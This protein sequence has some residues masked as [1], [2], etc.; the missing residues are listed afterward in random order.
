M[1]TPFAPLVRL[2][3][4]TLAFVASAA[5]ATL[6]ESVGS[7]TA[8]GFS[9]SIAVIYESSGA[10]TF[11]VVSNNTQ[12]TN[13][14]FKREFCGGDASTY[15]TA[16]AGQM[17]NTVGASTSTAGLTVTL[18]S[19]S[20]W[21]RTY[22]FSAI[23]L[24]TP[25]NFCFV[26][27][28]GYRS[29]TLTATLATPTP[30]IS[31]IRVVTD[32][33]IPGGRNICVD[34]TPVNPSGVTTFD[35]IENSVVAATGNVSALFASYLCWNRTTA[36]VDNQ[37]YTVQLRYN[38][39]T[40]K[41]SNAL[42]ITV[43]S[44][45]GAVSN[46]TASQNDTSIP[47]NI[48]ISWSAAT[49]ATYYNTNLAPGGV[50]TAV[51]APTTTTL[52]QPSTT[53]VAVQVSVQPCN[54]TTCG[55]W[56]LAS[57]NGIAAPYPPPTCTALGVAAPTVASSYSP[58]RVTLSGVGGTVASASVVVAG[59]SFAATGTGSTRYV[60]VPLTSGALASSYGSMAVT[61]SVTGAAGSANCPNASFV[62]QYPQDAAFAGQVVAGVNNPTSVTLIAGR[63]YPASFSYSNSGQSTWT[64]ATHAIG[65]Q[66]P[67]GNTSFGLSQIAASTNVAPGQSATYS[68][69]LAAPVSVGTYT[70]QWRSTQTNLEWFGSPST[71]VTVTVIAAPTAAANVQASD[72]TFG[73]RVRLTWT[74]GANLVNQHVV[75]A[76]PGT[77]WPASPTALPVGWTIV[78]SALAADAATCDDTTA[79]AGTTYAYRVFGWSGA[80]GS[81]VG[82]WDQGATSSADNGFAAL[83]ITAAPTPF[84]ASST[85]ADRIQL[86]W[87]AV[88]NAASYELQRTLADA[89]RTPDGASVQ[90]TPGT[91]T[92]YAD[93]GMPRG[94]SRCYRVRAVNGAGA[95][96][97]SSEACGS[98]IGL[99]APALSAS[100]GTV[101]DVTRLSWGSASGYTPVQSQIWRLVS[102]SD[103]ANWELLATLDGIV[104]SW[105]DASARGGDVIADIYRLH[106]VD[107][108]GNETAF[109][110]TSTTS[111]STNIARGY[112]NLA[113]TA[114]APATPIIAYSNAPSAPVA[115]SVTDPNV[116]AGQ[117]ESF[118]FEVYSKYAVRGPVPIPQGSCTIVNNNQLQWT[119]PLTLDFAGSTSCMILVT[120]KGGAQLAQSLSFEVQQFVP[121]APT[122]VAATD[123]TQT[124]QVTVTWTAPVG[125][126]AYQVFRDGVAVGNT[127]SLVW[128]DTQPV[129]VTV[130]AYTVRAV[131][132]A[133]GISAASVADTGFANRAPT[134]TSAQI[135]TSDETASAPVTPTVV[136]AN[137][138]D[139]FT[140]AIATQ[141]A[142]G[143]AAVVANALVYTPRT[144]FSGADSF[145]YT[146]TDRAGASVTGTA[147]VNVTCSPPVIS[148]PA[149]NTVLIATEATQIVAYN[150]AT[151]NT[152][153]LAAYTIK[154][155]DGQVVATVPVGSIAA[156]TGRTLSFALDPI[157]A[158]G[159]FTGE[160]RIASEQNNVTRS[161]TLS[162]LPVTAPQFVTRTL[163]PVAGD[164]VDLEV[165]SAPGSNCP[166]TT[167]SSVAQ[168]NP[169]KCLVVWG[170]L[171]GWL[172]RDTTASTN[173]HAFGVAEAGTV[174]P[175][176]NLFK[177]DSRGTR[178]AVGSPSQTLVVAAAEA[179]VFTLDSDRWNVVQ[180]LSP[181]QIT[182]RQ[183][184]GSACR[185]VNTLADATTLTTQGINACVVDWVSVPSGL[186]PRAT[187]APTLLGRATSVEPATVAARVTRIYPRGISRLVADLSQGLTVVAPQVGYEFTP[188]PKASY[189]VA[190]DTLQLSLRGSSKAPAKDICT[191]T[192]DEAAALASYA[193]SGSLLCFVDW[194]N[195]PSGLAATPATSAP[196]VRG[197]PLTAGTNRLSWRAVVRKAVGDSVEIA[198]G[199]LDLNVVLP[200][201]PTFT[202]SG[203]RKL[204][205]GRYLAP[206]AQGSVAKLELTPDVVGQVDFIITDNLGNT[207]TFKR[208]RSG[209][210]RMI[211][212]GTFPL[213]TTRQLTIRAA[214]SDYPAIATEQSLSALTVPYDF[215]TNIYL[216]AAQVVNDTDPLAVDVVMGRFTAAG[217]AYDAATMGDYDVRIARVNEDGSK[218]PITEPKR[219]S[220]LGS[221]GKLTF[222]GISAQDA[223][224]LKLV[225]VADIASPEPLFTRTLESSARTVQVVKGT[226][227]TASLSVTKAAGPAP[228][229]T[230]A[231]L[232][233]SRENQVAL[234]GIEWLLARDGGAFEIVPRESGAQLRL[235][236]AN[237]GSYQVKARLKNRNTGNKA[238]TNPVAITV[239]LVPTVTIA[240]P[241][242]V[243][244]GVPASF[245][246]TATTPCPEGAGQGRC[247]VDPALIEWTIAGSAVAQP[248][249]GTGPA[250]NFTA[251]ARGAVQITA[252]A[253]TASAQP[254]DVNAWATA[255]YTFI[256]AEDPKPTVAISGP[257]RVE[258]GVS[259]TYTAVV[260]APW[261]EQLSNGRV[262]GEWTL[263]D[264]S[265]QTSTT[266]SFT[267]TSGDTAGTLR[268]TAWIEGLKERTAVT[269]SLDYAAWTYQF[270]S[271]NLRLTQATQY[272]PSPFTLEV[273]PDNASV[274]NAMRAAGARFNFEWSA[275][276][277]LANPRAEGA[278]LNAVARTEGSYVVSV[279]VSDNRG[280][281]QTLSR[282][283]TA[284]PARPF[285]AAL[286]TSQSHPAGRVPLDV[287]ARLSVSGGHPDDRITGYTWTVDGAAVA[288][289]NPGVAQVRIADPGEHVIAVTATSR[290]GATVTAQRSVTAVANQAPTCALNA[291][292]NTTTR[293]VLVIAAC[294]DVDG[295]IVRYAW[296][297]NGAALTSNAD[298]ISFSLPANVTTPYTVEVTA[299][300][301][302]GATVTATRTVGN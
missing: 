157:V 104:Q 302:S 79:V 207:T 2:L 5:H 49:G 139:V 299:T 205:D 96:P 128:V 216:T 168:A 295:R 192:A 286:S 75:R 121:N 266:L 214:Y 172:N 173:L 143:S 47:G 275:A 210:A 95:G 165:R 177:F 174:T 43:P 18:V 259:Q 229:G 288:S 201:N 241:T 251:A 301:D 44:S 176:V 50:G 284:Q 202:I 197:T 33:A 208:V 86:A 132:H 272:A 254:N 140:F 203:G 199:A 55:S 215:S 221:A 262:L 160:T 263:P 46:V 13:W 233:L 228:L 124:D 188:Q 183:T 97:W 279:T 130:H 51:A 268:Y 137:L 64:A 7:P 108:A 206:L 178:Y 117:S 100:Q 77:S 85:Y 257:K 80:T 261:R 78:C 238:D 129:G 81:Q 273:T 110:I 276:P 41:L 209:S 269:A 25:Q 14:A 34:Y 247:P 135:T 246:I 39:S 82:G 142:N 152:N 191:P 296:K 23:P 231:A 234:A 264:G 144:G 281:T 253:R 147:T 52:R 57:T 12:S 154:A 150:A 115:L 65:T 240:G 11:D 89:T 21:S 16:A 3:L 15:Y 280:N 291:T 29:T 19:A 187:G 120:D 237:A 158:S 163:S 190:A 24:G 62:R 213:W 60:D 133:G 265:K 105:D 167:D 84:S 180:Y 166:L 125:A 195:L 223:L 194:V 239:Y 155:A 68:A 300:D 252:R 224:I 287:T 123:G 22:R 58:M 118:T 138:D 278:V 45:L 66:A 292:L 31:N 170:D 270:P 294:R 38:G 146:A 148:A 245:V 122:A 63:T 149:L 274:A 236:L 27:A 222:D 54:A 107:A 126:A 297:V 169:S 92:G 136:D 271:W 141:P 226:D 277:P 73:D 162:V 193:G 151:C 67:V 91:A 102:G 8:D 119:P 26:S 112:A 242:Y 282:T 103:L 260:G 106:Q 285:V 88:A 230:I 30:T 220:Q 145:T 61:A 186:A 196:G 204:A 90:V 185:L 40:S 131:S 255:R 182:V 74:P 99:T 111:F 267:P 200:T 114:L 20:S 159:S 37:T 290:M 134:A 42:S 113:P 35:W 93:V 232:T 161:A 116:T 256:V 250:I 32:A 225:A 94:V 258:T 72:G 87:G 59:T 98:R 69:N 83:A 289:T 235:Q 36:L 179:S 218:T 217:I 227:I 48:R 28:D 244:Q 293:T 109:T 6:T 70:L 219:L 298:R 127:D 156:G 283:I 243:L 76:A 175:S 56:V 17:P 101:T 248:Q 211:E 181:M 164:F 1:T 198:Q 249:T 53:G 10:G 212:A 153:L 71:A 9:G 189:V 171:P 4:T 184:A